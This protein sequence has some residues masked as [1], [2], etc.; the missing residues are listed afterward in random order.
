MA[1]APTTQFVSAVATPLVVGEQATAPAGT[2]S[3]PITP[4]MSIEMNEAVR[5]RILP[6][7]I[8]RATAM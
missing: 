5:T 6:V 3:S 8:D 7:R 2:A 4:P 1:Q